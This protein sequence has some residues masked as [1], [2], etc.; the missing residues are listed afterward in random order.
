MKYIA[1]LLAVLA[2]IGLIGSAAL[3]SNVTTQTVTYSVSAI[4][5]IGVS[6]DPGALAVTTATAGSEPDLDT[7]SSTTYAIS[8]NQSNRKITA[9]INSNV[10]AG[11]TLQI[12]LADPDGAGSAVSAGDVTLSTSAADVVTSITT[13]AA[14][15]KTIAYTFSATVAAGVVGSTNKTVTLTVTA[16]S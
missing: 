7:D 3:G 12:N 11:L 13:L 5:E 15:A 4:N 16:G 10:A 9:A 1:T 14:S 6:G 8:T 2:F